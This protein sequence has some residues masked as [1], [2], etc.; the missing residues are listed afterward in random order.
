MGEKSK[1]ID[2][3]LR[4]D[5]PIA[6]AHSK[7]CWLACYGMVYG[8]RAK[9]YSEVKKKIRDAGISTDDALYSDQ[10]DTAR[11][12]LG[13]KAIDP[14]PLDDLDLVSNYLVKY[15]PMWCAGDFLEGSGHVVL[16]SGIYYNKGLLRIHDPYT[17]AQTGEID[18]MAP[19]VWHRLLSKVDCSCQVLPRS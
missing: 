4:I 5:P 10:W 9:P 15:G 6:Q 8:W 2:L 19:G 13:L 18:T 17:L 14:K 1:K 3:L 12:A 16:L 11:R 7:C